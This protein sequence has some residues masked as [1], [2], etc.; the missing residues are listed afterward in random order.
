MENITIIASSNSWMEGEA[1][2]QLKLTARLPGMVQAVGLP[3]LHPGRSAPIGAAF[4]SENPIYPHLVGNDIGCGMSFWKTNLKTRRAKPTRWA[5]KLDA[6]DQPFTGDRKPFLAEYG[7]EGCED[8][9]LGTIG[10]GNHFAELQKVSSIT[11]KGRELV[12]AE[13]LY[14]LTHSGSRGLGQAI[15][16]DQMAKTG[17]QGL[18]GEQAQDYLIH[19]NRAVNWARANRDLISHRFISSISGE[20]ERILDVCHNQVTP[21]LKDG[22]TFWLHRKGAAPATE[23]PVIIPGSRGSESYLV[24]PLPDCSV[25]CWSLAHGAG[26]KWS[27][28]DARKRLKNRFNVKELRQTSMGS[29]VICE[30]RALLYEEAPQAYKNV[31]QVVK[32][33]V[34]HHLVEILA[35]LEPVLTFKTKRR[36]S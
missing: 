13:K 11:E 3:D 17:T 2:R 21:H 23:G 10:G 1:I 12:D 19:H 33:L 36:D 25:S 31:N 15:L 7:L 24:Q 5:S 9:A 35:V 30:D 18:V 27:R 16:Q 29:L 28:H 22:K 8:H 4:L 20:P 14:L 26:R 32:D 6:L 34:D